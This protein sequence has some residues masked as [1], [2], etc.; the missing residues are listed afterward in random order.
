MTQRV[1]MD[2]K[3]IQSEQ[4]STQRVE[5]D[6][7]SILSEQHWTS[8]SPSLGPSENVPSVYSVT[9]V[10]SEK[11][12]VTGIYFL[13]PTKCCYII[14]VVCV[15]NGL[16]TYQVY[17]TTRPLSILLYHRWAIYLLCFLDI[18]VA[19]SSVHSTDPQ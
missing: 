11:E 12:S 16:Y 2:Y 3:S 1:E 18:R 14:C 13:P 19:F 10:L 15:L 8:L 7:K 5:M 17:V 4:H 6:Y 9:D